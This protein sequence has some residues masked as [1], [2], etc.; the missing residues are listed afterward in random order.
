VLLAGVWAAAR[1]PDPARDGE[2]RKRLIGRREKLLQDLVRLEND[3][4]KGRIDEARFAARREDLVSAL[5]HVYGA[6]DTDDTVMDPLVGTR[7]GA[8]LS[9]LGAS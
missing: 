2:E 7:S 8:P 6:L 5:E 9:P 1:A 3:H 4:R